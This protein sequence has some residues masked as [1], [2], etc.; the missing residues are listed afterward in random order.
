METKGNAYNVPYDEARSQRLNAKQD[1][2]G[3]EPL[4][5]AKQEFAMSEMCGIEA[6][7]R[8]RVSTPTFDLQPGS[9]TM[10]SGG[11]KMRAH[12]STKISQTTSGVLV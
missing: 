2:F 1:L 11:P 3:G 9:T 8:Y 12:E 7:N 5:M 4:V 6:K 10:L